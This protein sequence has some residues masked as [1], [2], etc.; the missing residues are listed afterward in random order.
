MVMKKLIAAV[1]A[2]TLSVSVLAVSAFAA[3]TSDATIDW[4]PSTDGYEYAGYVG[5][6]TGNSGDVLAIDITTQSGTDLT[7]LRFEFTEPK[8]VCWSSQNDEG[9]LYTVDG[10]TLVET[11]FT[12]GET[13]TI[14]IDLAKSGASACDFHVHTSGKATGSFKLA[15]ITLMSASEVPSA[16]DPG[17]SES[18]PSGTPEEPSTPDNTTSSDNASSSDNTTSSSDNTNSSSDKTENVN[19]G[20]SGVAVAVG[21]AA[22]AA[23]ALVVAKKRK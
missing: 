5:A 18:Q 21:V 19:T 22:L 12:A 10:K 16:G 20:I 7:E 4:T 9:T 13:K 6:L 14:Y 11:A 15:N 17:E 3:V 1:S 8:K 23:G 2:A